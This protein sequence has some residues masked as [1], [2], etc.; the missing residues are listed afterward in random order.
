MEFL[1]MAAAGQACI[2]GALTRGLSS[3][4][5]FHEVSACGK[6]QSGANNKDQGGMSAV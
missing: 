1:G 5:V 3:R 2:V 6:V 4:R